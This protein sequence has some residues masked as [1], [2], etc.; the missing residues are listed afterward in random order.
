MTV[1][2]N[3]S[4]V[5]NRSPT[6]DTP[7]SAKHA[8]DIASQIYSQHRFLVFAH[9]EITTTSLFHALTLNCLKDSRSDVAE[10]IHFSPQ[11]DLDQRTIEPIGPIIQRMARVWEGGD[12][13]L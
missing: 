5:D 8:M 13:T 2:A 9:H 11:S 12:H 4:N 6:G 3:F 10:G 1:S 7:I